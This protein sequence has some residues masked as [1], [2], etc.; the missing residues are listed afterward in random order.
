[1]EPA[2]QQPIVMV[3]VSAE[4]LARLA[5][6]EI[7]SGPLM[8]IAPT[9]ELASTFGV[10][11]GEQAEAAALQLA[12]VLGLTGPY[13]GG[14]RRVVVAQLVGRPN[15]DDAANG[16]VVIDGLASGDVTA[17]FTGP[18]D[19]A[20]AGQAG[21]LN[22][23]DAWEQPGVQNLLATEPLGWHDLSELVQV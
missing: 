7:L 23:D 22:I 8:G 16:L 6:G 14:T 9:G 17:F 5:A 2:A 18:G 12:D 11:P 21:G 20:A 13:L 4:Q 10:E 3:P 15:P 19:P 1:M